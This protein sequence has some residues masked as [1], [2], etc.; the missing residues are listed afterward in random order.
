M[1]AVIVIIGDPQSLWSPSPS[2]HGTIV[3]TVMVIIMS[4]S[5][6]GVV[7]VAVVQ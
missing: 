4:W 7:V 6:P 3:V 2:C 5:L 1:V